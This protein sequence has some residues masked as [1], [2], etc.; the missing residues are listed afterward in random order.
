MRRGAWHRV[1]AQEMWAF[2][3]SISFQPRSTDLQAFLQKGLSLSH[4][5]WN[6]DVG[7][8]ES[9]QNFPLHMDPN[10]TPS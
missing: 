1:N 8:S 5:S 10:L 4:H 2:V 6:T 9:R 7:E 3:I